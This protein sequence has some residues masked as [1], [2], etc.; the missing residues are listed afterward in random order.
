[1]KGPVSVHCMKM[2]PRFYD[3]QHGY[4]HFKN[5]VTSVSSKVRN[6]AIPPENCAVLC[7][8][9]ALPTF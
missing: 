2:A 1:M 4:N 5:L 8:S 9:L 7:H 6:C 3:F